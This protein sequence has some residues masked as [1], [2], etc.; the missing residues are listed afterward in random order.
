MLD[1]EIETQ[2]RASL[3]CSLRCN[4]PVLVE[5]VNEPARALRARIW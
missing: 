5:S 1:V 4:V 3:R 2:H